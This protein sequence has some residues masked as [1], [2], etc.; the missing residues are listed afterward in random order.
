MELFLENFDLILT[1]RGSTF[2]KLGTNNTSSKVKPSVMI[3]DDFEDGVNLLL[4]AM[5][6]IKVKIS[7]QKN[8]EVIIV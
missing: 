2:E 5:S 3:F 8:H 6:E 7:K 1:S 4:V